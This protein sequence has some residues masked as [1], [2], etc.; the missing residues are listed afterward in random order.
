MSIN[1]DPS[2]I[3]P[4]IGTALL[5]VLVV[6]GAYK[7]SATTTIYIVSLFLSLYCGVSCNPK[8]GATLMTFGAAA[9][10]FIAMLRDENTKIKKERR[11]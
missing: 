4:M 9:S 7:K 2:T 8:L 6:T 1:I 5:F 10:L 11:R 3:L